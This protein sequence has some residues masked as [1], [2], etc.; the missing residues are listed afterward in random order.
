MEDK[1]AK[2]ARWTRRAVLAG[3]GLGGLAALAYSAAPTFWSRYFIELKRPV[4]LPPES[5]NPDRWPETGL[6]AAWIGH[7]TVL[8]K[9]DGFTILTDP[10]FSDRAGIS[11]GLITLGV[12]RLVAPALPLSKLP[13]IDLVVLSHAHMD[14]FD[15]PTLRKLESDKT[16]VI[17]AVNTADLLRPPRYRGVH[18]LRWG[19]SV[20]VGPV[21][22]SAFEVNHWGSRLRQD[23]YRGYNGYLLET[24]RY[25]LLFAGDTAFTD[26]FRNLRRSRAFDIA[27]LPIGCYN[28][29]HRNHCTPEEAWRMGNA[30]GARYFLPS[31]HQTFILSREPVGE[32]IHRFMAM[33]RGEAE[34]IAVRNIGHQCHIFS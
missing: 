27:V 1:T 20:N 6:H 15:I 8:L 28:P 17:T 30:A 23:S 7:A 2:N 33:A 11:L 21:R 25:R 34:R 5:P 19:E 22:A 31:H 32:P 26:T 24:G 10:I 4:E 12:K 9:C 14:H 18:E 16:T 3:T 13:R 29:W